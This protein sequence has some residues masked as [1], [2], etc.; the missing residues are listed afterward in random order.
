VQNRKIQVSRQAAALVHGIAVKA[1]LKYYKSS[2]RHHKEADPCRTLHLSLLRS[3]SARARISR[4]MA[5]FASVCCSRRDITDGS[6][7]SWELMY[8]RLIPKAFKCK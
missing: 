7:K 1:T 6:M 5:K 8:L 3:G 2:S 4:E